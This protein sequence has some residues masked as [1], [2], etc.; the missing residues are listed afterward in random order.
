MP[1]EKIFGISMPIRFISPEKVQI[2]KKHGIYTHTHTQHVCVCVCV[3]VCVHLH[4]T[5]ALERAL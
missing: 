2:H 1:D 3:C 4:E 5:G